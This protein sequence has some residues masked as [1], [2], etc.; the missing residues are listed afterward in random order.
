[1]KPKAARLT[2]LIKLLSASVGPLGD[3]SG[4]PGDDLVL[5]SLESPAERP[6]LDRVVGVDHVIAETFQ[7]LEREFGIGVGVE[8]A[9]GLFWHARW[10]SPRLGDRQPA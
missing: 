5:P 4:V 1:M 9:D 10:W 3:V 7:P 6:H 8:L 2:R